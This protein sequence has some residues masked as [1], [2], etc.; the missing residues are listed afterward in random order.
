MADRKRLK[1]VSI[2]DHDTI[3]GYLSVR[4]KAEGMGLQLI[5]GV[6]VSCFWNRRE[7]HILAYNFDAEDP[8]GVELL[9][10]Q[11]GARRKRRKQ[12]VAYLQGQ[13]VDI[14][15][16][17]VMAGAYGGNVGRPHGAVSVGT[18]GGAVSV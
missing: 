6:E 8:G 16:D 7:I 17:E 13:G 2:T 11:S 14:E 15:Y 3:Q 1:T 9:F 4:D 10:R 12:L 18:S 5:S